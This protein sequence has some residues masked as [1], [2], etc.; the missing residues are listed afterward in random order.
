VPSGVLSGGG[1]RR[2]QWARWLV[3]VVL[4]AAGVAA[5][6]IGSSGGSGGHPSRTT[7]RST[8][9]TARRPPHARRAPASRSRGRHH[10]SYPGAAKAAAIAAPDIDRALRTSRFV[11]GGVQRSR[12]VALTFDDGPSPYTPAIVRTLVRLRV[13][14]TFF[15]VGQ[16]L[17]Y[18]SNGLRDELR[19]G[20][21]VGDHTV[22]HADLPRF[23]RGRQVAQI[24][25]DAEMLQAAGAPTVRLFRPP[26]GLANST[27]FSILRKLKM[28]T[29]L[30]SVDPGDWRRPGV[31]AIVSNVIHAVRPGSIVILHDG[32]GD[33]T[34]TNAAL[35]TIVRRLRRNHYRLVSVPELLR[36]DPPPRH[37]KVPALTGA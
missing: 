28:L 30:W 8:T 4:V 16:Q 25:D 24:K 13:P 12:V 14:A 3:V 19:S 31:K 15:V 6:V 20:F 26:Y 36:L 21:L 34:Q 11:T 10:A 2:S 23:S 7:T 37:Q 9:T 5:I 1:R 17:R 22:N 35:P 27:T 18:F 33:R 32:G 29:V